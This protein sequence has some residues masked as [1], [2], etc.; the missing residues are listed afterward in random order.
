MIKVALVVTI[1]SMGNLGIAPDVSIPVYYDSFE[2]CN[3]QL[4]SLKQVVNAT[5]MTNSKN[6]RVLRM[7]NREYHHK[8]YIFWSCAI[9]EQKQK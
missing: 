3:Q 7:E 8:S 1:V 5:E 9:T 6:N 2:I 4:D